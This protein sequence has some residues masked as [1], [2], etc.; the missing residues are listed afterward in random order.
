[1]VTGRGHH[2]CFAWRIQMPGHN[3]KGLHIYLYYYRLLWEDPCQAHRS[4]HRPPHITFYAARV[5]GAVSSSGG[6]ARVCARYGDMAPQRREG[7]DRGRFRRQQ[8][9]LK[10]CVLGPR[11]LAGWNQDSHS[12]I[13]VS[14]D[15]RFWVRPLFRRF[16]GEYCDGI[17][18]LFISSYT[19][20]RSWSQPLYP[21][22]WFGEGSIG[23]V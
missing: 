20:S 21:A 11:S 12:S 1:V 23:I 13:F 16:H 4:G 15:C 22:P 14:S 7:L 5:F 3:H 10:C 2:I 17:C 8:P 9:I 19:T 6:T 18:K